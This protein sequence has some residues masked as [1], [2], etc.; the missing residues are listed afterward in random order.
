MGQL[1]FYDLENRYD[2]L[3]GMDPLVLINK[4]V[5][6]EIFRAQLEAVFRKP[7]AERKSKAGRKPWD[8][9]LM[10]K[11]IVLCSLYN[12]SDD[13]IEYQIRDRLSFMRFLGLGLEDRVPDAKTVW[14]YRERLTEAGAIEGLFSQFND[15][16]T[17]RGFRA[18]G[19]QIIDASVVSVPKQRN[20]RDENERI[21]AGETP[22]EWKKKPAKFRQKDTDARWIKKNNTNY[23][24]YKN[25]VNVDR[26]NK[27]IRRYA[28]TNAKVHDIKAF[29]KV[30]SDDNDS[31]EVWGDK[32]YYSKENE[33]MLKAR[34]LK[35]RIHKK[36]YRNKALTEE[37]DRNNTEQSRIRC[38]VEHV[39]GAQHNDMGGTLV[40]SIGLD[41][42]TT[43]IGLK[44]LAYNIRRLVQLERMAAAP[45]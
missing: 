20:T 24:G 26:N 45:G 32:A 4:V 39:F 5:D 14:H 41:R 21:K 12:L 3:D 38:R 19:G 27:F 17:E 29:P 9:V 25:T 8:A 35:S 30:L 2:G 33:T 13:Q 22:E 40:R 23:F 43:K 44:N 37:D 10:F 42:V 34:G 18:N 31:R 1:G 11:T 15:Y 28:V 6:W 16:L 36:G 7:D